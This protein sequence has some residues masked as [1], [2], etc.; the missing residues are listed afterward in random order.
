[1][2]QR[3][4][5]FFPSRIPQFEVMLNRIL[6]RNSCSVHVSVFEKKRKVLVVYEYHQEFL[7]VQSSIVIY[8]MKL[9]Y[10]MQE[11]PVYLHI[12]KRME[13]YFLA[14]FPKYL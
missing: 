4:E 5:E 6:S 1:M 9:L 7:Y 2:P 12:Y 10:T 13:H 11:C 8:Y 3:Q 14:Y